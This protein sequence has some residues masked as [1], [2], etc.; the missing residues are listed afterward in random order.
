MTGRLWWHVYGGEIPDLSV[1]DDGSLAPGWALVKMSESSV[2][3]DDLAAKLP[4]V[5]TGFGD[6]PYLASFDHD[7]TPD[8][9]E[10]LTPEEYREDSRD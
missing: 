8:E 2:S 3:P 5:S 4:A 9:I 6:V 1:A 10:A 7:P